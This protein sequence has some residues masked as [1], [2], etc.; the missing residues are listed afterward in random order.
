MEILKIIFDWTAAIAWPVAVLAI[1]IMF[2]IPLLALLERIGNIA[3]R[4]SREPFDIQLGE[5]LKIS[6]KDAIE[7]ANPKTVEEAL[8]VAEIE[9]EKAIDIYDLLS[10]IPLK[11]HHKDLLLKVAKGGNKGIH[12]EYGGLKE[13]APGKTMGVLL[14]NGLVHRDGHQYYAHPLVREYIFRVHDK[15]N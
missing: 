5:K 15:S 4:A 10:R 8:K 11:P 12:W 9:A 7:K 3:D 6:F 13:R 2:K 1:A 14:Q